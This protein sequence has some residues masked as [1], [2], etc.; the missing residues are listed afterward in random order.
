MNIY[1]FLIQEEVSDIWAD[2]VRE[3][4]FPLFIPLKSS[5]F[6]RPRQ[7]FLVLKDAPPPAPADACT[8][9]PGV[10]AEWERRD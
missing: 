8:G 4:Q 7:I 1:F 6:E 9:A 3:P 5:S 2:A 10:R